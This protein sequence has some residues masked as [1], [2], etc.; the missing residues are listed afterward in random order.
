[1]ECDEEMDDAG[2]GRRDWDFL[3]RIISKGVDGVSK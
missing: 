3:E 1:M 2:G